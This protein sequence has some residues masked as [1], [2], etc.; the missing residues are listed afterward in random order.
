MKEIKKYTDVVRYG[1]SSTQ[2]VIQ[3][4]DIISITEKIDGANASFCIDNENALGV[5]CYS[6]NNLLT[7]ENRLRGY[8]DWILDNIVPIKEELNPNYRYFGEW[9]V[10]HKVIYKEENYYKFY[11][12][13]IWDDEKQMYLSD[14]IVRSEAERLGLLTVEYFYYGKYISFEHLMSFV[15]KSE[16]TEEPNTGE[17]IVVKNVSY[18]D[19]YGRQ[20]FVKLVSD[21]FREVQQQ[22]K[23]KNPNVDSKVIETIKSVLT[24]ARVSKLIHKLVDEGLLKEDFSIEDM[25]T[26]LKELKDKP[27]QDIIKEEPELIGNIEEKIIKR[28]IGKNIPNIVKEVLKEEN[29]M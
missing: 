9:L 7:E 26:I 15:G 4:G 24:K 25:G 11:L 12:F 3:E 27:Y 23:P 17:G 10:K 8:Y 19:N 22:K 2:G 1:K 20:V 5:S 13:S 18:F 6:R 16:L 14:E 29:R 21:K 28:T